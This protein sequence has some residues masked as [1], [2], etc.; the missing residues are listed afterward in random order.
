MADIAVGFKRVGGSGRRQAGDG[1]G[2]GPAV[3][4]V[5]GFGG[6]HGRYQRRKSLSARVFRRGGST[7]ET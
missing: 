1:V 2:L 3:G 6:E 4:E 5:D 7:L